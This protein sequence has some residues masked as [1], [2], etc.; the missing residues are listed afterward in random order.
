MG[1]FEVVVERTAN[2][3]MNILVGFSEEYQGTEVPYLT[4]LLIQFTGIQGANP[5]EDIRT[6]P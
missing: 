5:Y 2:D 1:L 6:G 4:Y 3:E